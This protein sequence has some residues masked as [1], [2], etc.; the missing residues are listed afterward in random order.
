[1]PALSQQDILQAAI[2]VDAIQ[3]GLVQAFFAQNPDVA[4]FGTLSDFPKSGKLQLDGATW[5]YGKHG[6]GYSFLSDGGCVIDAHD[7]FDQTSHVIDAH[8]LTEYF[9]SARSDL[10]Q[11]NDLYSLIESGLKTLEQQGLLARVATSPPAWEVR[12]ADRL[13][14]VGPR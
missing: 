7:H 4:D 6:L 3:R 14:G 8:R 13:R 5:G 12:P 9:L 11:V 1:M 2:K 10:G